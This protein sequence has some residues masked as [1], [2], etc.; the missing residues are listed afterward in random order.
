MEKKY[1]LPE[2]NYEVQKTNEPVVSYDIANKTVLPVYNKE[3][4]EMQA[5]QAI[6]DFENGFCIP[7]ENIKR[8]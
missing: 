7:H 2:E 5:E 1:E 8:K 4:I 3:I 6:R